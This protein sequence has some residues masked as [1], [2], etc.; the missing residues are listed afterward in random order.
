M[1]SVSQ[2]QAFHCLTSSQVGIAW[3]ETDSLLSEMIVNLY[4]TIGLLRPVALV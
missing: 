3:A 4:G 1:L 2:I